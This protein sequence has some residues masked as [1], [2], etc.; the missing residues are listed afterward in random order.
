MTFHVRTRVGHN[1]EKHER[2]TNEALDR[3]YKMSNHKHEIFD[4]RHK[5]LDY[6]NQTKINHDDFSIVGGKSI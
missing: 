3:K 4:Y 2:I 1:L 5:I 6:R